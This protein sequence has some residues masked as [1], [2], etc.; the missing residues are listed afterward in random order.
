MEGNSTALI[1]MLPHSVTQKFPK[2]T[3]GY[4]T[5]AST[6]QFPFSQLKHNKNHQ[7]FGENPPHYENEQSFQEVRTHRDY[8]S[9]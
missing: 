3:A 2:V 5:K 7:T 8:M 4:L 9:L 1:K 6:T